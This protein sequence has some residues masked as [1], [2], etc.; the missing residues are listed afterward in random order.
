VPRIGGVHDPPRLGTPDL[1]FSTFAFGA[2]LVCHG[3]P[4]YLAMDGSAPRIPGMN[5]IAGAWAARIGGCPHAVLLFLRE[6]K[7]S[8]AKGGAKTLHQLGARPA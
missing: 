5:Q 8:L 3:V 2:T 4:R 7:P 6:P 1:I